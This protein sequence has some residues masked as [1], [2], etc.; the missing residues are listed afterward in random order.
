MSPVGQRVVD[1]GQS[2]HGGPP[3]L[4]QLRAAAL[5]PRPACGRRLAVMPVAGAN[6][7]LQLLVLSCPHWPGAFDPAA[8]GS[9]LTRGVRRPAV[10][11][12]RRWLRYISSNCPAGG[13]HQSADGGG[14]CA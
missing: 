10:Q 9:A 13:A 6:L 8:M 1:T 5:S 4:G 3:Q 12:P 14:G 11:A 2:Q 7:P